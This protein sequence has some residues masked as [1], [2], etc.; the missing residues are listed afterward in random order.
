LTLLAGENNSGK[1]NVVDA[2][3][4]LL[5]PQAG[6]RYGRWITS[7]DFHHDEGGNR[8]VDTF[9]LTATFEE[10]NDFQRGRMLTCLAPSVGDHAAR[11]RLVAQM[12]PTGRIDVVWY[13]G[14]SMQPGIEQ[15]ARETVAHTFLHPLRDAAADL[16]PGRDN[17]LVDLLAALAPEDSAARTEIETAASDA[18][19]ALADT[20]A[21][22]TARTEVQDRL[23]RMTGPRFAQEMG[24]KF[25]DPRFDRVVASL[26]ALAGDLEPLELS[27]NG[28]GFNNLLYMAVLLAALAKEPQDEGLHV[29]LV[30]EP[31]AH[32]HPQLQDLLLH[33][34]ETAACDATQVVVTTHS[35]NFAA[36]SGVERM[37]ILARPPGSQ[38]PIARSPARFGLEQ[39]A[40]DHLRR[41]LDVTKASLLFSRGVILVEGV[42][43]QL[44]LPALAQRVGINLREEGVTIVNVGGVSFAPFAALFSSDRLPLRCAVVSDGD[45]PSENFDFETEGGEPTISATAKK[46]RESETDTMRVFLAARTFEWDLALAGNWAT[47]VEALSL[48]KPKTAHRLENFDPETPDGRADAILD[49]VKDVK[50][51]FAQAL[52]QILADGREF[53]V[54]DYLRDAILWAATSEPAG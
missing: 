9:E 50:G 10:L 3:R 5:L 19:Q 21:I 11:L 20:Q 7:D 28:L 31:E 14:D 17:K 25:A 15:W 37:T 52:T 38:A 30:E 33:Y 42:A 41:F 2:L 29:L 40:T 53:L 54:P 39:V 47:M 45:P 32:L 4:L 46:L 49:A 12:K 27:E 44:L 36:A 43:E 35:P 48:L 24:L 16:R 22:K 6:A 18:N 26:R 34:L 51:R 13:G 1:S 23:S 8:D